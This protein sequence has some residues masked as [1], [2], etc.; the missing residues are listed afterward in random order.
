MSSFLVNIFALIART[1]SGIRLNHFGIL[2]KSNKVNVL[3]AVPISN[4]LG[5]NGV[6]RTLKCGGTPPS[7][8]PNYACRLE[9]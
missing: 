7:P 3:R 2:E 6:R 9:P 5:F 1:L 4:L 8:T